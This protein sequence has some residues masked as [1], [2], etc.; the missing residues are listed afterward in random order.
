MGRPVSYAAMAKG[1]ER[2]APLID[3]I[4]AVQ[5]AANDNGQP[6]DVVRVY[7]L[8]GAKAAGFP[9]GRDYAAC[10]E[11]YTGLPCNSSRTHHAP[12]LPVNTPGSGVVWQ[13]V[14]TVY[15]EGDV[16]PNNNQLEA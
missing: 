4:E 12:R 11:R 15:P 13:Y 2:P 1:A 16:A 14:M 3:V 5:A 9:S 6:M 10:A 7:I 8:R